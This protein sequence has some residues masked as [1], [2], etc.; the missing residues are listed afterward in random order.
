MLVRPLRRS[1]RRGETTVV[2]QK[3]GE[4]SPETVDSGML[5]MR[6]SKKM[7]APVAAQR[8]GGTSQWR[9]MLEHALGELIRRGWHL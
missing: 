5:P 8:A 7:T 6:D 9:R 1:V 4:A 3:V 2:A